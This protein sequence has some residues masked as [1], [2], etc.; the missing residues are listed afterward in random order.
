[1]D[2]SEQEMLLSI[3]LELVSIECPDNFELQVE[4]RSTQ[5]DPGSEWSEDKIYCEI[6]DHTGAYHLQILELSYSTLNLQT[7]LQMLT[8]VNEKC[9]QT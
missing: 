4:A 9:M 1:M 2:M 6:Q 8:C 5:R 3:D 7:L